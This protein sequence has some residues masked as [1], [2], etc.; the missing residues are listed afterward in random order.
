MCGD[1]W[2]LEEAVVV[3]RQLGLGYAKHAFNYTKFRAMPSNRAIIMSG[4]N[5]HLKQVSLLDCRHDGWN[6]SKC[7]IRE[8]V[9]GVECADGA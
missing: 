5:C 4:V 7:I 3:C 1:S 8:R 2:G 6:K 9:A